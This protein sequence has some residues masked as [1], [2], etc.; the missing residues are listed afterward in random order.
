MLYDAPYPLEDHLQRTPFLRKQAIC[1]CLIRRLRHKSLR[2]S[3]R[4]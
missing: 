2:E 4:C 1:R 3:V